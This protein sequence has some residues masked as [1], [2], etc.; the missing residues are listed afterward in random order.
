ML[1]QNPLATTSILVLSN[2]L[3]V[4]CSNCFYVSFFNTDSM[5]TSRHIIIVDWRWCF[6]VC[7][8]LVQW[9]LHTRMFGF[10]SNSHSI[11]RGPSSSV[12]MVIWNVEAPAS[13]LRWFSLFCFPVS[14]D[15]MFTSFG[16]ICF[17]LFRLIFFL[18]LLIV[19]FWNLHV[20]SCCA[21]IEV[22]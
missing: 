20:L 17:C 2:T 10:Q 11:D 15:L 19:C 22:C 4:L 12:G 3:A 14:L 13:V 9:I 7:C 5:Q 8:D 18:I 1:P 16:Y 6:L 21:V